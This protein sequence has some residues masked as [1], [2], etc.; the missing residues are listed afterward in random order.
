MAQDYHHGVRITEINEGIRPIPIIN[1]AIIGMVCTASDAVAAAF[2]LNKPVLITNIQEAIGKAGVL[3]TLAKSLDDIVDQTNTLVVVVRVEDGEGATPQAKEIDQ[4]AKIIG[5]T[6]A[7]GQYTGMKALL[8]AK[9]QLRVTPRIL[10]IPYFDNLPV[11]TELI[12]IEQKLRGFTYVHAHGATTKEDAVAYRE[13]FGQREVMVLWSEFLS[14]QSTGNAPSSPSCPGI[15][16][17]CK[18]RQ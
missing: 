17:T 1:T 18:A 8:A 15:G 5:T 9:T 11:A 7:D 3:G 6:T 12:S 14:F 2:P 10:G 13:N 16:S 4:N